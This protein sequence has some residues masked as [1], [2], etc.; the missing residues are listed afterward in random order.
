[1][2]NLAITYGGM[3]KYT[4]AEKLE[5]HVLNAR[6]R[7]LGVEHPHT[8]LSMNNLAA[9]YR[10][11]ARYT[12]AEKLE[13]QA[14]ELKNRVLGAES[15]HTITTIPHVQEAQEIQVL[16]AGS[17]VHG[18]ENLHSRQVDLNHLLEFWELCEHAQCTR[19]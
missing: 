2:A 18:E 9:T 8:I 3:K 4:E 14:H 5:I 6:N 12:E 10:S 1:M 13:M 19:Y 7:I 17:T 15:C 16:G 11:L